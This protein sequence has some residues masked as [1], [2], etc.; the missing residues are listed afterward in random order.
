[1]RRFLGTC[2]HNIDDK[3]RLS[4][5]SKYRRDMG[6]VLVITKGHEGCLYVWPVDEWEKQAQELLELRQTAS[7][8]RDYLRELA[9]NADEVKLDSHGRIVIPQP[10]R[11]LAGLVREVVI[12]GVVNHLELW[13]PE[14]LDLYRKSRKRTFEETSER[15]YPTHIKGPGGSS[16]GGKD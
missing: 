15:L 4:I 10:L 7:D 3:G 6:E 14:R 13:S 9:M 5:P 12:G 1:M 11:E 2:Y 8:P 16:G